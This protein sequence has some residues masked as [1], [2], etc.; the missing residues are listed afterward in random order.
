MR[1]AFRTTAA[2]SSRSSFSGSVRSP[3]WSPTTNRRPKKFSAVA[4]GGQAA[5]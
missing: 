4:V 2:I 1:E 3:G 5:R